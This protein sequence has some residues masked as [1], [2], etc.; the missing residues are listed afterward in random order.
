MG[1]A[2]HRGCVEDP[3]GMLAVALSLERLIATPQRVGRTTPT[4][5]RTTPPFQDA[6]PRPLVSRCCDPGSPQRVG[7]HNGAPL[8]PLS[9]D[10]LSPHDRRAYGPCTRDDPFPASL[11]DSGGS[12]PAR[13]APARNLWPASCERPSA[14]AWKRRRVVRPNPNDPMT[15]RQNCYVTLVF[16]G[17][18]RKRHKKRSSCRT[19]AFAK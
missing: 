5:T 4:A 15:I 8:A 2:S 19:L 6:A 1:L 16:S 9:H 10:T 14:R 18:P 12:A 17:I 3:H 7:A 11:R 13:G